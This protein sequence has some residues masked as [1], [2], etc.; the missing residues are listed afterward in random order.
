VQSTLESRAFPVWVAFCTA[1][2][3]A[4]ASG[5]A[6]D[7]S[8]PARI[9]AGVAGLAVGVALAFATAAVLPK[10]K[11]HTPPPEP[12]WPVAPAEAPTVVHVDDRRARLE[13]QLAA[14][15]DGDVERWIASSRALV[16]ATVPGASGY[17]AALGSRS[18][19]DEQSRL[20][21]HRAR[22]ATI[23]RDFL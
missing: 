20:D 19:D 18:F 16:D 7:D 4:V 17:F 12:A 22:L 5:I 6:V 23:V 10:P 3:V 11:P 21:A 8:V 14:D 1:V 9:A 2:T 15:P 13:A